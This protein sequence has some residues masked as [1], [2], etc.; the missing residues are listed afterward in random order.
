MLSVMN[1]A[2]IQP[3]DTETDPSSLGTRWNKWI[4]RFENFLVAMNIDSGA[5][6]NIISKAL[7]NMLSPK[8]QLRATTIK[9]FA[10]GSDTALPII[11][12]F[13]CNV[14]ASHSTTETKFYVLQNDGH[15]L[16]S[17]GTAQELGL[18][19][20]TSAVNYTNTI[21]T[22]A[23]ELVESYPELFKGIG[24][25]KNFQVKL[26]INPDVQPTCQPHR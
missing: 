1:H 26:H 18:I 2:P 20:I 5:A 16:L 22:V 14:Q 23:D 11:G 17:Y 3:F 13:Q 25:L 15:T 12:V 4:Q 21:H 8:P 9:I 24:K 6:V 7:F 19:N 10:Y